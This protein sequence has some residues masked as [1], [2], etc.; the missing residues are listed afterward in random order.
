MYH[1]KA[2][3]LLLRECLDVSNLALLVY[4]L[5]VEANALSRLVQVLLAFIVGTRQPWRR[6][7]GRGSLGSALSFFLDAL[8]GLSAPLSRGN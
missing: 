2:P 6:Y 1:G 4:T 5:L 3:I 8:Y 7:G